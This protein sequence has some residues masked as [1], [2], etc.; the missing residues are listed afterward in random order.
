MKLFFILPIIYGLKIIGLAPFSHQNNHKKSAE[1]EETFRTRAFSS[2]R[3]GLAYNFIILIPFQV[4]TVPTFLYLLSASYPGGPLPQA[5]DILQAVISCFT[6][7]VIIISWAIRQENAAHVLNR[8][9][10]IECL[11][12]G[13]EKQPLF[14]DWMFSVL[15]IVH[16]SFDTILWITFF[17]F[18]GFETIR[19]SDAS[20]TFY[21]IVTFVIYW[22]IVE[23]FMILRHVARELKR[24]NEDLLKFEGIP[25]FLSST[26]IFNDYI[27]VLSPPAHNQL[28]FLRLLRVTRMMLS[29]VSQDIADFFS[30]PILFSIFYFFTILVYTFYH[31]V[32]RALISKR[33]MFSLTTAYDVMWVVLGAYPLTL[34]SIN[35][36]N[37]ENQ[38]PEDLLIQT[39]FLL[40]DKL[41]KNVKFGIFSLDELDESFTSCWRQ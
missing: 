15:T 12:S 30:F 25:K 32:A 37:V 5:I 11:L 34:L 2:S 20:W 24:V 17:S 21:G 1:D 14:D 22:F 4:I 13:P 38:V 10:E 33:F 7:H 36:T 8:L 31:L 16:I 35:V 40:H 39:K 29:D 3:M 41:F 26:L 28:A 23:Y 27:A 6:V 9:S 18:L 19:S